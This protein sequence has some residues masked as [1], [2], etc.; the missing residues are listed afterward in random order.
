MKMVAQ[1]LGVSRSNLYERQSGSTKPRRSYYKAQ[2][3]A[4]LPRIERLVVERPTYGSRRITAVL[5]RELRTESLARH[6]LEWRCYP[7]GV[8]PRRS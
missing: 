7:R 5:N 1:T 8:L 2:D 3:A 6:L 4:L